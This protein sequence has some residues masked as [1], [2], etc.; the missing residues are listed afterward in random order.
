MMM[1]FG[2]KILLSSS[3]YY[4]HKYYNYAIII[5]KKLI[6]NLKSNNGRSRLGLYIFWYHSKDLYLIC[7]CNIVETESYSDINL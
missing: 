1:R 7:K 5:R 4:K 3:S 6:S 2:F